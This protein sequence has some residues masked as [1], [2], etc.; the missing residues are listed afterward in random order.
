VSAQEIE[1]VSA[2]SAELRAYALADALLAGERERAT[3]AYVR[4][5]EQGERLSG[6]G[7]LMA[8]RLRD[9]LA[10][11]VRLQAGEPATSVKRS[12]RMPARAAERFLA[13][14]ARAEPER[15]REALALLAELELDARGGPPIPARRTPAAGLDEDTLALRAI[16]SITR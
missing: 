4:L 1:R 9:G 16:E 10:A 15:L 11:S 13:D 12:L 14:A 3:L 2:R 7:Y 8:G 5:R 6:L